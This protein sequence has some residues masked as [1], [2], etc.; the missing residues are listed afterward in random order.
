MCRHET[1]L[2]ETVRIF[3]CFSSIFMSAR[4]LSAPSS[5]PANAKAKLTFPNDR[6]H[7]IVSSLS[8]SI[9]NETR[10]IK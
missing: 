7:E 5:Y 10:N 6:C 4:D 3:T 2:F 8:G 1:L 9:E